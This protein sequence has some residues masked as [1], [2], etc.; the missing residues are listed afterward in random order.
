MVRGGATSRQPV[1]ENGWGS[2]LT[3]N[4]VTKTYCAKP[5][6]QSINSDS[7]LHFDLNFHGQHHRSTALDKARAKGHSDVV[8]L[9]EAAGAASHRPH[10]ASAGS[11]SSAA[12][13]SHAAEEGGRRDRRSRP[14]Q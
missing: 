12:A 8:S 6:Q 14:V 13:A 4:S 1:L 3:E 5:V 11:S 7:R 10:H 9:L 2:D